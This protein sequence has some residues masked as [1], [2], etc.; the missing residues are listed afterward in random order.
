MHIKCKLIAQISNNEHST[1][2][3]FTSANRCS[4][5]EENEEHNADNKT[6]LK[7]RKIRKETKFTALLYNADLIIETTLDA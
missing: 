4:A 3:T 6:D 7:L 5:L 2:S 1:W